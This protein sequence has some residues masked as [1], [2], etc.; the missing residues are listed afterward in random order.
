MDFI[1]L[2]AFVL[3]LQ[4]IYV[5][6]TLCSPYLIIPSDGSR[7]PRCNELIVDFGVLKIGTELIPKGLRLEVCSILLNLKS[8]YPNLWMV[9]LI[10]LSFTLF[11]D[12]RLISILNS[13]VICGS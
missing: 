9:R 13:C 4:R 10:G 8:N 6:A 12:L 2:I 11:Y 7:S 5:D 1:A 3:V